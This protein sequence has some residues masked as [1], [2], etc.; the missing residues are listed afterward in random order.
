MV[1]AHLRFKDHPSEF[2]EWPRAG[3]GMTPRFDPPP[4]AS[5]IKRRSVGRE[6]DKRR[7]IVLFFLQMWVSY[8]CRLTLSVLPCCCDRMAG[9][10]CGG[11]GSRRGRVTTC[12]RC[13]SRCTGCCRAG[14][15][16]VSRSGD[17]AAGSGRWPSTGSSAVSATAAQ[18][19]WKQT[20]TSP[21][22]PDRQPS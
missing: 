19:P 13:W 22:P 1:I 2:Q 17:S 9:T 18:T 10:G 20:W 4:R 7:R 8:L 11:D 3:L 21:E 16:R 5:R 15:E 14:G 6:T 12:C